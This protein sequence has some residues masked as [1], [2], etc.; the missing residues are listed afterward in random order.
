MVGVAPGKYLVSEKCAGFKTADSFCEQS[1]EVDWQFQVRDPKVSGMPLIPPVTRW[2][3]LVLELLPER[4][5]DQR[6]I[7]RAGLARPEKPP[8]P[9]QSK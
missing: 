2:R 8:N 3:S 7:V 5:E 6:R 4:E 9:E 1:F